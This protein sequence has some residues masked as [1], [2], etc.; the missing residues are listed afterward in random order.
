MAPIISVWIIN[1]HLR[2]KCLPEDGIRWV[3]QIPFQD[4]SETYPF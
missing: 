1:K 4:E 2:A 3:F